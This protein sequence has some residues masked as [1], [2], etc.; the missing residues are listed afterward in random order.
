VLNGPPRPVPPTHPSTHPPCLLFVDKV[1]FCQN[2]GIEVVALLA[3]DEPP[4]GSGDPGSPAPGSPTAG[5]PESAGAA[6]RK[7]GGK[8]PGRVLQVAPGGM[9]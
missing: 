3:A 5:L 8:P 9:P 7:K 2:R 6:R 1:R 4:G